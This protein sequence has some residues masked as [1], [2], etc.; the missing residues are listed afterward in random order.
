MV[1]RR[2][3]TDFSTN[4]NGFSVLPFDP[5][6]THW[7]PATPTSRS[8][9]AD[10]RQ[11]Y[12]LPI[13]L[14]GACSWRA[15]PA[16]RRLAASAGSSSPPSTSSKTCDDTPPERGPSCAI[17]RLTAPA[18]AQPAMGAPTAPRWLHAPGQRRRRPGRGRR[19]RDGGRASGL[20]FAV[21]SDFVLQETLAAIFAEVSE[22]CRPTD[23]PPFSPLSG[24]PPSTS[25]HAGLAIVARWD[26]PVLLDVAT[27]DGFITWSGVQ[28]HF[29][30]HLFIVLLIFWVQFYYFMLF[31]MLFWWIWFPVAS[32]NSCRC[33]WPGGYGTAH[34]RLPTSLFR[35]WSGFE[36]LLSSLFFPSIHCKSWT[37][38]FICSWIF[39]RSLIQ[40]CSSDNPQRRC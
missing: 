12:P 39:Y 15:H 20:P 36:L 33:V 28:F 5:I 34:G 23:C 16:R 13:R 18:G 10:P 8:H 22:I 40:V 35:Q 30:I 24:L 37:Y 11:P 38:L 25:S 2:T 6:C 29:S 17:H 31:S 4:S 21:D 3:V 27:L 32:F 9:H 1:F 7:M 26:Q 19:V 14:L